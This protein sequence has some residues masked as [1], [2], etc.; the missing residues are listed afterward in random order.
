MYNCMRIFNNIITDT[1]VNELL[2]Y[3]YKVDDRCDV[4]PDVVSKHPRWNTDVWP[5]HIIENVLNNVLDYEYEVDDIT[6]F[7][8]KISYRL[9]VDSGYTDKDKKGHNILLPLY[10]EG[11][12][13]TILFDNY[14]YGDATKF[15]KRKILQFEY[16]LLDKNGNWK[17]VP[18]VRVL[19]DDLTKAED[20]IVNDKFIADLKTIINVRQNKGIAKTEAR[21]YDY[22]NVVNYNEN[23]HIDKNVYNKYLNHLEYVTIDGLQLKKIIDWHIGDCVTFER[24]TLHCSSS[25]HTRKIGVTVFTRPKT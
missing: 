15:S 4:R 2:E 16:N 8:S 20:F 3:F 22:T 18:D 12:S 9:H 5:Q 24:T 1:D 17:Y 23:N 6:F 19:L 11:D 10:I 21:C 7:D 14:W 25:T 13:H